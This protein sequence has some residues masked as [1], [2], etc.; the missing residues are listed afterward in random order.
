MKNKFLLFLVTVLGLIGLLVVVDVI[1]G[2]LGEYALSKMP[3]YAFTQI[4]KD[5][6]RLNRVT[7]DI[8]L[9]GSSRCSRH[10][11]SKMLRDSINT[12]VGGN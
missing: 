8:V 5:N 2:R 10:Y 1:V 4:S 7:T 9:V 6:Y 3:D 12:Y 11:V